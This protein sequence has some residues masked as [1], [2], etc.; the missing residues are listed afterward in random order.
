MRY[1]PLIVRYA[2]TDCRNNVIITVTKNQPRARPHA[3][4]NTRRIYGR[5]QKCLRA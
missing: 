1:L 3:E 2:L 4:T 5:K